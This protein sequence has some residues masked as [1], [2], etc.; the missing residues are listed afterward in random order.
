MA[1]H[2]SFR[3]VFAYPLTPTKEDGSKVDEHRFRDLLDEFIQAGSQGIVVLRST[4][5]IGSFSEDERK[6]LAQ[7]AAKHIDGRV[8]L[9]IGTGATTT[10]EAKRL[11]HSTYWDAR[12]VRRDAPSACSVPMIAPSWRRSCAPAEAW[13]A[14]PSSVPDASHP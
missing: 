9:L 12:S 2:S 6:S 13:C 3:G 1:R 8:P 7:V 5:A 11:S 4:G 14:G 10:E